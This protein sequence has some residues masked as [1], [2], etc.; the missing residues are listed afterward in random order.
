MQ[1][2]IKLD[3]TFIDKIKLD[4]IGVNSAGLHIKEHTPA[5]LMIRID[6]KIGMKPLSV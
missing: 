2:V 6:L 5:G 3:Q 4:P 1:K